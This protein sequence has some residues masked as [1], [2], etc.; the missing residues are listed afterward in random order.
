MANRYKKDPV[1]FEMTRN[2]MY[3]ICDALNG[4]A[5]D[6]RTLS[7]DETRPKH[8]RQI[9]AASAERLFGLSRE[10]CE[11]FKPLNQSRYYFVRLQTAREK[12]AS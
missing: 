12:V 7:E 5:K 3:E 1:M 8:S 10:L 9:W 6:F 11:G 2:Q 4:K